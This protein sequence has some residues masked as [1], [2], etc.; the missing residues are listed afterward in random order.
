M[1]LQP[2]AEVSIGVFVSIRIGGSEL[3]M[4]ILGDRKGSQRQKKRDQ[5][6]GQPF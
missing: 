3:M 5:A 6:D 4:D 2:L 1:V